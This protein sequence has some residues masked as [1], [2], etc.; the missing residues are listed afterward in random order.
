[1]V[2]ELRCK[3][4]NVTI[5]KKI[6]HK[7]ATGKTNCNFFSYTLDYDIFSNIMIYIILSQSTFL[8]KMNID[9]ITDIATKDE[10]AITNIFSKS[11]YFTAMEATRKVAEDRWIHI[12]T[13]H[14]NTTH[15]DK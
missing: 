11:E 3:H 7:I 5:L 4:S 13:L 9:P 14:K 2:Y 8:D 1:M 6:L 10:G 15:K 12:T